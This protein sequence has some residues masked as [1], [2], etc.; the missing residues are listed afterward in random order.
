MTLWTA[1]EQQAIKPISS[2]NASKFDLLAIETQVKDLKPLLGFDFYQDLMNNPDSV[3]NKKLLDGG[4]YDRGGI[5]YSF[6][7]AEICFSLFFYA[8]YVMSSYFADTFTGFVSKNHEDA[9]PISS[10]DRKNLRDINKE[11]AFQYWEDC[12]QFIYCN[13]PDYPYYLCQTRNNKMITL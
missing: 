4:N 8:N 7:R 6:C 12:K 10:G 2:N 3:E 13:K 5:V 9:Q 1:A 11:V